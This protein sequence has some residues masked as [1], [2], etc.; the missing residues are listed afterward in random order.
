MRI[1]FVVNDPTE[2]SVDQTTTLLIAAARRRAHRVFV[3]GIGDLSATE[4]EGLHARGWTLG[5]TEPTDLVHELSLSARLTEAL[6]DSDLVVVRTNPGRDTARR[7]EH[8]AALCL[9]ARLERG[10]VRVINSPR[11]LFRAL[12]KLSLLDLPAALRPRTLVTRDR[13][14]IMRFVEQEGGRAVIKPLDG[15]RGRDVFVLESPKSGANS[16]QIIEVVLRQGYA[17]VQEFVP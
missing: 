6:G 10:G 8:V 5:A 9:L 4:D 12:T 3:C 13:D 1:G 17:M 16:N 14:A 11:G 15:T 7:A 2:L